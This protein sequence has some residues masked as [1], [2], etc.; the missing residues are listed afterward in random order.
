M[1]AANQNME[2]IAMPK[3][4]ALPVREPSPPTRLPF[5]IRTLGR[6]RRQPYHVTAGTYHDDAMLTVVREGRGLYYAAGDV[7][8]IESGHVGLVLPSSDPG[9][10]MAD[11]EA[12]YDHYY[13]RFAGREALRMAREIVS[14]H[15]GASF[16][17]SRRWSE[18]L[19]VCEA[20]LALESR[21]VSASSE[22]MGEGEAALCRLLAL[23]LGNPAAKP[24]AVGAMSLRHY[25]AHHVSRPFDL[26]KMAAHFGVS[27]FHLSRRG[28]ALLGEPLAVASRRLRLELACSLL[29]ASVLEL[30]VSEVARR[31]GYDDPLYFSKV[32]RR[33]VGVSPR[34]YR[35]R[36]HHRRRAP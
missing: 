31:V 23:L 5:R 19:A 12:P 25:L 6:I 33:Y 24:I 34:E 9:L 36:N 1:D 8:T 20:M 28:R 13:C 21:T 7:M 30:N 29:D 4:P 2:F 10:L 35:Q 11:P 32:F 16:F 17:P 18:A 15:G 3:L 22:W 27:R 26:D 14:V